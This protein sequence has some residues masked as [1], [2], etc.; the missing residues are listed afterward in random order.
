MVLLQKLIETKYMNT[1][2]LRKRIKRELNE[3][4]S[5]I[6]AKIVRGRSYARESRKH[7]ELLMKFYGLERG[8]SLG[9]FRHISAFLF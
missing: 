3:L 2:A 4:N 6:D 9:W 1:I 5:R 8:D 7:K